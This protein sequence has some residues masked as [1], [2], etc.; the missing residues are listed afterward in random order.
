MHSHSGKLLCPRKC[1]LSLEKIP[2]NTRRPICGKWTPKNYL[3]HHHIPGALRRGFASVAHGDCFVS[4]GTLSGF[5]VSISPTIWPE[6]TG[7]CPD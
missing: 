3:M 4:S 6:V 5:W 2:Q 1:A 7:G